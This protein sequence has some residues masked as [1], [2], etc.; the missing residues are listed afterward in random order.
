M[1]MNISILLCFP[2]FSHER[3]KYLDP[4]F[5]KKTSAIKMEKAMTNVNIRKLCIFV[6]MYLYYQN[7][8][9]VIIL[10]IVIIIEFNV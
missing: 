6:F 7:Y 3:T 8:N 5:W 2:Q 4:I 9:V 1:A 10:I